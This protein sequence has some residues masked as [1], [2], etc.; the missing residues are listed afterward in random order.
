MA[1]DTTLGREVALKLLPDDVAADADRRARFER[2]ARLVAAVAH[3]GIVTIHS[4]EEADG[5]LF[6]TME[7]V[8]GQPLSRVIRRGGLPLTQ[9]LDTAV[10]IADAVSAAHAGESRIAT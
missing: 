4:I 3:P 10:S 8:Q 9:L 1:R 2:E 5:R 6:L 7:L